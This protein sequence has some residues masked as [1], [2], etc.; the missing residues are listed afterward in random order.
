MVL[1]LILV[2]ECS[3]HIER[4]I[5]MKTLGTL[6]CARHESQAWN[7]SSYCSNNLFLATLLNKQINFIELIS[8]IK[9]NLNADHFNSI[10]NASKSTQALTNELDHC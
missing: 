10:F 8:I 4:Q 9:I 3:N 2:K 6:V 5:L 1:V 7:D